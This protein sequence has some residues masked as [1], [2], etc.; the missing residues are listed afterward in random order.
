MRY[1]DPSQQPATGSIIGNTAD[2]T[3]ATT[4]QFGQFW[5]EL[6]G[7]FKSNPNVIFG[8]MNEPHDMSTQLIVQN[9]QAAIN[10]IR[11][12]GANQLIIAPGNGYTGGHSWNQSTCAT[13]DPSSDWL[14]QLTD[15][16]NNL[17]IDIHEYLDVDFSGSH[18]DCSQPAPPNLA[19]LTSWLQQ[20]NLKAMITEFG[21][22]NVTDCT[23][24]LEGIINYMAQNPEYIGWSAWAA[25]PFWGTNSPCCTDSKQ[26][27]SLEPGIAA[28]GGGPSLYTSVWQPV[29]QPL[30]PKTLQKSGISS[31]NGPGGA[32]TG[33]G[34]GTTTTSKAPA[35]T[36]TKTSSPASSPTGGSGSVA[37]YG[38]CGGIGWTG[39]IACQ[40]PYTCQV[41]N[42]YYSQCL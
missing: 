38:Q 3:A 20:H 18:S 42:A 41:L 37:H 5:G 19:G 1:N 35:P 21:G 22:D 10:A 12:A 23:T 8:L 30:L 34:G 32:G 9:N 31:I 25:G 26:Y 39:A 14:Y 11:A 17:A 13:C 6:A 7:R 36:T 15:S 28:A 4:A 33:S 27:G 40:S 2:P 24:D 29:I 16:A